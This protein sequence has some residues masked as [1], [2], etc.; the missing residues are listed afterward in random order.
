[1]EG[2]GI[3]LPVWD[4]WTW[5]IIPYLVYMWMYLHV[6]GELISPSHLYILWAF[7]LTE[8]TGESPFHPGA[9]CVWPRVR[10]YSDRQQ[11]VLLLLFCCGCLCC[12]CLLLFC[13]VFISLESQQ[14]H[15]WHHIR[16]PC[17]SGWPKPGRSAL[18]RNK[19]S[20]CVC[21]GSADEISVYQERGVDF[22]CYIDRYVL[23]C[24]T[25]THSLLWSSIRIFQRPLIYI[26]VVVVAMLLTMTTTMMMITTTLMFSHFSLNVS[27]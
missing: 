9:I 14:L 8:N 17:S 18:C 23:K 6:F 4:G 12:F 20:R 3:F 13:F 26:G 27:Q 11:S 15:V 25:Q 1:M 22:V 24:T 10:F 19:R 16:S 2:F 21:N 5:T 7:V